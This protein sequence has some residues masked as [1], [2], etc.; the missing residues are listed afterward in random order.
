MEGDWE[1]KTQDNDG[2]Q[3]DTAHNV[4]MNHVRFQR[5][6]DVMIDSRKDTT[7]L[8]VSW[9]VF[10]E[11]NKTFGIGWTDNITAEITIHHTWFNGTNTRNPS[12]D[13]ILRAHLYNNLLNDIDN[14]GN[15][16]R[17]GT[18]MVLENSIFTN[19]KNTHYY[20]TGS[21]GA[22]GNEYNNVSGQRES[23]CSSYSFFNPA[24][25]Y[26]YKLDSTDN[27]RSTLQQCAGPLSELGQQLKTPAGQQDW[28]VFQRSDLSGRYQ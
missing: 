17:G 1:G 23:S 5:L 16:S 20:D 10:E 22:I 15:Y 26:S 11:H 2:V 3:I 24:A 4:W 14:Y 19:V 27:L 13:N 25:F 8:T 12:T 6:G 7:N 21:L 18:N 28:Q 9:N